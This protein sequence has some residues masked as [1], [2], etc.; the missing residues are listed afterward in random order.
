VQSTDGSALV[1]VEEKGQSMLFIQSLSDVPGGNSPWGAAQKTWT[2]SP[3]MQFL[4]S[5]ERFE[6][7]FLLRMKES[8]AGDRDF[9]SDPEVIVGSGGE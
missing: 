2:L 8:G 1:T 9:A 6:M 5:L 7:S 4:G 3:G